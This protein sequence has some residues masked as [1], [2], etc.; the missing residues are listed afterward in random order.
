MANALFYLINLIVLDAYSYDKYVDSIYEQLP[1][2]KRKG[3]DDRE[4]PK[5]EKAG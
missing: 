5:P 1:K 4:K 3:V 2:S